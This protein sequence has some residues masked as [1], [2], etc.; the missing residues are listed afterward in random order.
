MMPQ[1]PQV[2]HRVELIYKVNLK[3]S[4]F[5]A[6][7]GFQAPEAVLSGFPES[8]ALREFQR[9]DKSAF[10]VYSSLC[11]RRLPLWRQYLA[12]SSNLPPA[13]MLSASS[14]MPTVQSKLMGSE[15]APLL[16][17]RDT[18][19]FSKDITYGC[20]TKGR[21]WPRVDN[22]PITAGFYQRRPE[23]RD[24]IEKFTADVFYGPAHRCHYW[25]P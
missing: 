25:S 17:L 1:C 4:V 11:D 14:M 5:F 9:L 15:I 3:S 2:A 19:S 12:R 6:Y 22:S 7:Q 21:S 8:L 23:S 20:Q 10:R 16:Q 18:P 13:M 24:R